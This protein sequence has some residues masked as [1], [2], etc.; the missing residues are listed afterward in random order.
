[1]FLAIAGG[2][3]YLLRPTAPQTT[4]LLAMRPVL[5]VV[6]SAEYLVLAGYHDVLVLPSDGRAWRSP[7]LSWEGLTLSA[8]ESTQLAGTGWDMLTDE[9]VSFTLD[10]ATQELKGGGYRV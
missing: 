8:L 5:E 6:T 7:R 4:E 1:M 2:Y 9:E 3:A 10:L